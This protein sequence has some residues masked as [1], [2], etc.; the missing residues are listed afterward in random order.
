MFDVCV[1]ACLCVC[2]C[3]RV[4]ACVCVCALQTRR[5]A[6][7]HLLPLPAVGGALFTNNSG[8]SSKLA[9]RIVYYVSRLLLPLLLKINAATAARGKEKL[10]AEFDYLDGLLQ[11]QQQQQQSGRVATGVA[12]G[13]TSNRLPFFLTGSNMSIAG[14]SPL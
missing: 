3:M 7:Y 13:D 8:S 11:E 6:Y 9:A 14:A 1:C 5:L 4:R 12:G 10:L 2:V